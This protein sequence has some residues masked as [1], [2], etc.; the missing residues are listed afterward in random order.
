MMYDAHILLYAADLPGQCTLTECNTVSQLFLHAKNADISSLNKLHAAAF[1]AGL[2][3]LKGL[4]AN[5]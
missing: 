4:P 2:P 3:L 1:F 5:C